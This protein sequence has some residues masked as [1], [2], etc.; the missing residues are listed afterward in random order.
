MVPRS[1][2]SNGS[3]SFSILYISERISALPSISNA[4]GSIFRALITSSGGQSTASGSLVSSSITNGEYPIHFYGRP[5]LP[6]HIRTV[7]G[8]R[9]VNFS[10]IN[11]ERLIFH[12]QCKNPLFISSDYWCCHGFSPLPLP[13]ASIMRN[14][15]YII[16]ANEFIKYR[17][18]NLYRTRSF[19]PFKYLSRQSFF[20]FFTV[21]ARKYFYAGYLVFPF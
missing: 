8:G 14:L 18:L 9:I 11:K 16:F 4:V 10:S 1:C 3:I 21:G 13:N 20:F 5:H 12:I 19:L 6:L 7:T 17:S 2:R 15:S